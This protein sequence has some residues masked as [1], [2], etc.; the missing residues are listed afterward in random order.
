MP[1][2][3]IGGKDSELRIRVRVKPRAA[4]SRV[5]CVRAGMLEVAVAAPPVDGAANEELVRLISSVLGLGRRSTTL[6]V[7]GSSRSRSAQK[8]MSH[9]N[10]RRG[11]R[12]RRPDGWDA[13]HLR[14][15]KAFPAS[16][17]LRLS[18]TCRSRTR[19]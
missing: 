9:T 18:K 16:R 17:Q 10:F 6:T 3:E 14:K 7:F 8:T 5:L 4:R 15:S 12:T 2:L 13:R 19:L 11:R 1:A